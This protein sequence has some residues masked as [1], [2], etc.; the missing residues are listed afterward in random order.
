V[1]MGLVGFILPFMAIYNIGL[2]L[3]GTPT[4]IVTGLVF[5]TVAVVSLTFATQGIV[6]RRLNIFE[7]ILFLAPVAVVFFPTPLA[8]NFA[9]VGVG[10]IALILSKRGSKAVVAA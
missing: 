3:L 1:R 4:D 10:V 7:R 6:F 8:I 5:C 2:L 9:A